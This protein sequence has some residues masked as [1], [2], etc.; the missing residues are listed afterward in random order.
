MLQGDF[1]KGHGIVSVYLIDFNTARVFD[2]ERNRDTEL[3]GTRG[4]AAPEQYG[5]RSQMRGRIST[6]L[7]CY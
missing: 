2:A 4:F 6:D 7:A 3:I 1:K 5:F